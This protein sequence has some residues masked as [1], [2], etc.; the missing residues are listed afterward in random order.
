MKLPTHAFREY[1]I[2][3]VAD[4]DLTDD[5]AR[6][7][8]RGFATIL[9]S[10][11]SA[12]RPLRVAVGRDCRLSSDRLF[13]A[14]TDGLTQAGADV[15]EIGV[16]PTPMLYAAAHDLGTDGGMMITGSHNPG[17][18][19]GFKMMRG[20]ASFFGAQIQGLRSLVESERFAA[21]TR[22]GKIE[23]IDTRER[24][25]EMVTSRISLARTDIKLV[26]D[27]GNGSGGPLGLACMRKLGLAPEALFCDMDGRFPNHHPDPT[28]PANLQALIDRVRATHARVGI[29]YDGDA[30]R[31]GAVDANGEI[32]WGDRLMILFSRALLAERPGAAILGEV[33]CSQTLYDDIAKHGGRPILWKTGHSLIKTKMKEEGALLAGEMSGHLFFA[34]RYYGYDDAIYASLRLLEILARDPRSLSEMLSDVPQ[35]FSTP[36]IRVDCPDAIKFDVVGAV[37]NHY[38]GTGNPVIDIDGARISFGSERD[39]A[40]GLVRAS[41]TGPI[42]VMRFE[43]TSAARRDAI[44][45]EVEQVVKQARARLGAA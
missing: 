1:D 32:V 39:P 31:L 8:G 30:D 45:G 9:A 27:A 25:V 4:R 40:W 19:N 5:T 14:L 16:G 33:K 2:R 22:R 37:R 35:A 7:I 6:G 3:G 28:V 18:E 15:I 11:A 20:K 42:L 24:Y 23:K 41:N 34:D 38:R 36:E 44:R 26:L 21:P 17:D 43:A 10:D 29:A 13:A 12:D